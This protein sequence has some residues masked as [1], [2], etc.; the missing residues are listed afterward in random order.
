MLS[1]ALLFVSMGVWFVVNPPA[2]KHGLFSNPV[3]IV[4]LG[5]VTIVFFG[6]LGFSILRKLPDDKPGLI[7]NDEGILDNSSPLAAGLILW[8]DIL[9][10]RTITISSQ[11]ML[12]I[13][14][15]N[16]EEYINRQSSFLKRKGMQGNYKMYGSPIYISA[17]SLTVGFQEL[18][19]LIQKNLLSRK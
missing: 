2:S 17:N 11:N 15:K 18:H 5:V 7:I 10:I 9:E 1:G 13:S 4:I 3:L 14:V 19:D 8:D 6:F 16:P 12:E